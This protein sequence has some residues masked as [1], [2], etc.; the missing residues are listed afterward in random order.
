MSTACA[1]FDTTKDLILAAPLPLQTRTYK[2][3]SHQQ[4]I[5]LTLE[6]IEKAGFV[7]ER[8]LYSSARDG[9]IANG[10]YHLKYGDDPEMGLMIGWQNSYDK[11]LSL[12]FA[13]GAYMHI[14][15]NGSVCG[16]IG[17]FRKKHQGEIQTF[18]PETITAYIAQAGDIYDKLVRDK[19]A[20]KRI[21]VDLRKASEIVGRL[22]IQ[23]DCIS[24]T[25]INIV[26]RE[27]KNPT[28]DYGCSGSAWELYNHCT[29]A[30]KESHP[31]R[32][33][34][35]HMKIHELFTQE[36]GL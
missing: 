22:Y 16:D 30:A 18:T 3:I 12:K 21:S 20:L 36:F 8:E 27:I 15:A 14:C 34:T 10:R 17:A 35:T 4:L 28:Y 32:W 1:T 5:D 31:T 26:K 23:E 2:P 13:I 33:F 29:L 25:Q 11:S 7:L 24:S 6:G 19:E 9:Q